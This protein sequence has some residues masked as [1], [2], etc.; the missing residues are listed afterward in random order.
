MHGLVATD[1]HAPIQSQGHDQDQAFQAVG[2]LQLRVFQL[3]APALKVGKR[4]FDIP[5][6]MPL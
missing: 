3:E 6:I 1:L 4:R 2:L 5:S